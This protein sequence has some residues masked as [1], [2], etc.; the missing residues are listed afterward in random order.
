MEN[1]A[2]KN[3]PFT[4]NDE[5]TTMEILGDNSSMSTLFGSTEVAKSEISVTPTVTAS[6]SPEVTSSTP[7]LIPKLSQHE[8]HLM[9]RKLLALGSLGQYSLQR[10]LCC[11]SLKSVTFDKDDTDTKD[12]TA[13][14]AISAVLAKNANKVKTL[15]NLFTA[16]STINVIYQ[17]LYSNVF[18]EK[19]AAAFLD[20]SSLADLLL[21]IDTYPVSYPINRKSVACS[22]HAS[23]AIENCCSSCADQKHLCSKCNKNRCTGRCCENN[24][25][26]SHSCLK[27]GTDAHDCLNMK[28]VCCDLCRLCMKCTLVNLNLN[29]WHELVG[30]IVGGERIAVCDMLLLR[31]SISLIKSFRNFMSH[32]TTEECRAIDNGTFKD[33][34]FPQ[35]CKS[36]VDIQ[37]LFQFAIQQILDYLKSEDEGFEYVEM[38]QH[39]EFMRE[40]TTATKH[41]DI[42]IYTNAITNYLILEQFSLKD[43]AY[44]I[45]NLTYY[46][47]SLA[48]KS[49]KLLFKFDFKRIQTS[50]CNLEEFEK[51][52]EIIRKAAKDYFDTE[53]GTNSFTAILV[54]VESQKRNSLL[55]TYKI[56]SNSEDVDL[57]DYGNYLENDKAQTLWNHLKKHLQ[58]AFPELIKIKLYEWEIE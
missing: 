37:G 22:G 57:I 12:D 36:W 56:K 31:L 24:S 28:Y 33:S 7:T 54:G 20:T 15:S 19:I 50:E 53:I 16:P 40:V 26:C 13:A 21:K 25:Y 45:D 10:L 44:K 29:S 35:F 43:I 9:Y 3:V 52:D 5:Q 11:L 51:Y 2:A 18:K 32:L 34:K 4:R 14:K 8:F 6:A 48:Q 17:D 55:V 49:L 27:C 38:N 1:A 39:K 30:K 58:E 42:D 41:T 47:T 23:S 46:L